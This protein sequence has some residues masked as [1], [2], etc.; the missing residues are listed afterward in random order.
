[1][2]I[3]TVYPPSGGQGCAGGAG[4]R[5]ANPAQ[6]GECGEAPLRSG[7][8]MYTASYSPRV[9]RGFSPRDRYLTIGSSTVPLSIPVNRR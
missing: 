7:L 1:M 6:G 8:K 5:A 3:V 2:Y 9:V 4:N